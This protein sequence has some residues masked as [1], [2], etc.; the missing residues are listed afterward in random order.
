[1]V[2]VLVSTVGLLSMYGVLTVDGSFIL[3][4][5]VFVFAVGCLLLVC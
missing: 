1:M 5:V 3:R 4:C 2:F